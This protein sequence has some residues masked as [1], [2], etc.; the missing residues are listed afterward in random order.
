[1]SAYVV[2]IIPIS[3]FLF[4]TTPAQ[5]VTFGEQILCA[6]ITCYSFSLETYILWLYG[7]AKYSAANPS[8]KNCVVRLPCYMLLFWRINTYAG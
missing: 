3:S 2:L 6:D 8:L 1:M 5:N 4:P 7:R